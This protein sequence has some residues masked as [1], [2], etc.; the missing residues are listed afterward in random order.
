MLEYYNG[1]LIV[2]GVM[3]NVSGSLASSLHWLDRFCGITPSTKR[4]QWIY[5]LIMILIPLVPIFALITQNIVLV[6]D[7][8]VRKSDLLISDRSVLKS[9]ETARLIAALQ[10][11]RSATLM[12][13]Y[14]S[15]QASKEVVLDFNNQRLQ[16]DEALQNI[17]NWRPFPEEVM[18][19]SK[20]RLQIRIDDFRKLVDNRFNSNNL[21][22]QKLAFDTLNFYTYATRVLLG[23]LSTIFI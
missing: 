5:M 21:Q 13:I 4:G 15:E 1:R 8:L 11:E 12:Q 17:T 14:L 3:D 18:F 23:M 22:K 16:T 9:D 20:L 10:Q 19:R 6:N 7:I 2:A